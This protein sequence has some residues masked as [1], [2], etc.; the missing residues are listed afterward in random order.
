MHTIEST[1]PRTEAPRPERDP[2]RIRYSETAAFRRCRRKWYNAY[3]LNL[4]NEASPA[5]KFS[6]AP[7]TNAT[8]T[9]VHGLLE[10]FYS[11]EMPSHLWHGYQTAIPED[12]PYYD[13]WTEALNLAWIMFTGYV[14][15][16]EDTGADQG[17]RTV[18]CESTLEYEILPG[19]SI[20]GT[21]DRIV[22]DET[23]DRHIIED[24]KTVASLDK[25]Q[26]FQVDTQLLTYALLA[27]K[28]GYPDAADARQGPWHRVA[29]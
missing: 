25:G 15:W 14:D 10:A 16:T 5:Q 8:G 27:R 2:V 28:N 20:T 23:W 13:E 9:Y 11:E 29:C 19:V 12:S 17:E 18:A 3:V 21:I 22:Y 24:F 26:Q 1:V 7:G 6:R 4:T